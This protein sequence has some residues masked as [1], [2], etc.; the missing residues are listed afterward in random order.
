[1]EVGV[2]EAYQQSV[3]AGVLE[4]ALARPGWSQAR[5]ARELGL[6]PQTV[7]KWVSGENTP[8]IDR[9]AAIEA[10]L[11]IERGTMMRRAGY[12]VDEETGEGVAVRVDFNSKIAR[13]SPED[14][15]YVDE[16]VERLLRER[17]E[18]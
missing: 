10:A 16:L 8:P 3:V 7:N 14:Q 12:I 6:R 9:W 5:L 4:E 17:D 18:R 15:R 2:G 11:G 13:L 1:M